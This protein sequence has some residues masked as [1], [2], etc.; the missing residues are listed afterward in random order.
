MFVLLESNHTDDE[1]TKMLGESL[2]ACVGR[3]AGLEAGEN[4]GTLVGDYAGVPVG[5]KL[6]ALNLG[7]A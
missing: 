4:A 3:F 1:A 2:G 7:L 5:E 6:E